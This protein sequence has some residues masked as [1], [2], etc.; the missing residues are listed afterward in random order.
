MNRID[1][2]SKSAATTKEKAD[3]IAAP[4]GPEDFEDPDHD[5]SPRYLTGGTTSGT[6]FSRLID[7]S[8]NAF[9][10]RRGLDPYGSPLV[11]GPELQES[12]PEVT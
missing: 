6:Q 9:F 11:A 7:A 2:Y 4:D 1:F 10:I 3:A 8:C 5:E 12:E